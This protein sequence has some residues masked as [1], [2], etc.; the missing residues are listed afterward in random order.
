M[1]G[2]STVNLPGSAGEHELQDRYRSQS[3]ALAFYRNQ[4]IDVLNVPMQAFIARQEM[5]FVGTADARGEADVSIRAGEPGFV[6]VI[7][8]HRLAY[9]EYRGNGVMASLGNIA[10]NPH[11]GLL[12]VDFTVD[13][14]GLHVNG[15]ARIVESDEMIA[16]ASMPEEIRR[17]SVVESGKRAERWVVVSIIEAYIHCSKHIPLMRK[18]TRAEEVQW[19]TDDDR[20]KGGDFFRVK[21]EKAQR[22]EA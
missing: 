7:D 5:M 15:T 17:D 14:I 1:S 13:K 11:V 12:F 10:E 16:D 2:H 20:A 8:E 9:P 22:E 18:L 6:R 4:V 3:R 19:G 21:A